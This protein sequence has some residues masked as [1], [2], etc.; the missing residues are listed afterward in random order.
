VINP[1]RQIPHSLKSRLQQSLEKNIWLG[2]LK[3]IDQSTDWVSNLVIV[4]KKDGS[5]GLCLDPKDLNKAIK[6]E[7][8]K[9]Q[10][11]RK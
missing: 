5:L 4:E 3:K 8:Y 9:Y 10:L 6:R 2:V 11:W 7:H 1:P